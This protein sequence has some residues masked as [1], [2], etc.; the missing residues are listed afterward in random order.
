QTD[1]EGTSRPLDGDGDNVARV[2]M[3]AYEAP[4]VDL[5]APVTAAMATPGPGAGGWN[6]TNVTVTLNGVDHPAG[7]GVESI[8]YSL[9][10]AVLSSAVVSGNSATF[11]ITAEG[12]TNITYF[13]TDNA[14]NAEA[15]KFLTIRIDHTA[16]VTAA[17]ATPAPVAG[18]NTTDVTVH[19]SAIDVDNGS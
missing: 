17:T 13:A 11:A 14:G 16:P 9:A 8:S 4:I 7:T 10:G 2:D 5:L 12:I 18:W 6:T 19:L 1:F 3:G 15:P